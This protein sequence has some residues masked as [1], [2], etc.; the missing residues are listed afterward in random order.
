MSP[1][2]YTERA[3]YCLSS[4]ARRLLELCDEKETNLI[5]SADV[6]STEQLLTLANQL[7]PE[8]CLLKTHIDIVEDFTPYLTLELGKLAHKHRFLIFEDRKFSDIGNTVKQQYAGGMYH[9]AEW[10]D[11]TNAHS[12]PGPGMVEGLAEVGRKKN[13]G[14]VLVAEMS[15]I[16]ALTNEEYLKNTLKIAEQFADFVIGFITQH[17]LSA[18]PHWINMTPGVKLQEGKDKLGQQYITPEKAIIEHHADLIIVG[19]GIIAAA[20]PVI[21]CHKYREQSWKAYQ[22]RCQ[23]K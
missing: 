23:K 7:G 21:E 9:I 14:L 19:R 8:I 18:D 17:A 1:L 2:S 12:L 20:D 10:A 22:K 6:T 15:S 13:R 11:I 3:K 5:L 16:G 4:I